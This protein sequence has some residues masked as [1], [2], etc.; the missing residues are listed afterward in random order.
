MCFLQAYSLAGMG[1]GAGV[2]G[3]HL[4]RDILQAHPGA[5][6]LFIC[7]GASWVCVLLMCTDNSAVHCTCNVCAIGFPNSK[8]SF[9]WGGLGSAVVCLYGQTQSPA[10]NKCDSF[11]APPF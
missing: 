5:N 1:C 9:C 7:A 2:I 4:V 11:S 3:I 6:A 8:R 10:I